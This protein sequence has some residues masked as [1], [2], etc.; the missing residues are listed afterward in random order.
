MVAAS[1]PGILSSEF[2]LSRNENDHRLVGYLH[3]PDQGDG[4]QFVNRSVELLG[5]GR[6]KRNGDWYYYDLRGSDGHFCSSS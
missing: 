4:L 5:T 3:R 1:I 2:L 6:P